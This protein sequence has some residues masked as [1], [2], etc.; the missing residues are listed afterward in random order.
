MSIERGFSY[1]RFERWRRPFEMGFWR[2]RDYPLR[3]TMAGSEQRL[4]P[5]R[6]V[7]VHRG[8]FVHLDYL[9]AIEPLDS[10]DPRLQL[11]D[12]AA[13]RCS[14]RYRA[15]LREPSAGAVPA[16]A[17]R[18]PAPRGEPAPLPLSTDGSLP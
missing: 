3:A 9:A 5:D 15:P 6:F 18:G 14:R 2:R 8:C 4:D 10:G 12:G 7:R 13:I 17:G 11:H 16:S 1:E